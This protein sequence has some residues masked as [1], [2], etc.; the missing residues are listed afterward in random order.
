MGKPYFWE[1]SGSPV[2]GKRWENSHLKMRICL[3]LKMESLLLAGNA[4]A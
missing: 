1:K 4:M 2:T 3:F